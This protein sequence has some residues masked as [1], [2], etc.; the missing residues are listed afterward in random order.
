MIKKFYIF[1]IAKYSLCQFIKDG[2]EIVVRVFYFDDA[3][4]Q[5]F[6]NLTLLDG[7]VEKTMAGI[8]GAYDANKYG[9][10]TPTFRFLKDGKI[11]LVNAPDDDTIN[12]ILKN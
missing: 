10:D 4:D 5:E 3:D 6:T 1:L 12:S 11:V 7:E 9:D 2:K 8:D